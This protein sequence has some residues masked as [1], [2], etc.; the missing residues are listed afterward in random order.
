[1]TCEYNNLS[2]HPKIH[3][4]QILMPFG[5]CKVSLIEYNNSNDE[6]EYEVATIRGGDIRVVDSI[7]AAGYSTISTLFGVMEGLVKKGLI[8]EGKVN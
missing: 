7:P 1:M 8:K 3:H 2:R 4:K 5:D 6:L